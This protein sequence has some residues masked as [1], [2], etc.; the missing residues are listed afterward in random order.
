M[1][2]RGYSE[3]TLDAMFGN[4]PAVRGRHYIQFRKEKEYAKVLQD[5]ENFLQK[6][7][8]GISENAL[9]ESEIRELLVLRDL[10]VNQFGTGK[11]AS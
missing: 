10:L 6:L 9:S 7:R 3:K 2:E 8:A 11:K 5:N 1:V 4:S